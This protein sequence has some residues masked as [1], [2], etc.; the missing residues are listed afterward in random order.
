MVL[1]FKRVSIGA[2]SMTIGG[3]VEDRDERDYVWVV[4]GNE[5]VRF[6]VLSQMLE[7]VDHD[8][9]GATPRLFVHL[10]VES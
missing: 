3:R 8:I 10:L 7:L 1:N 4:N 6:F 2:Q 9:H 5:L